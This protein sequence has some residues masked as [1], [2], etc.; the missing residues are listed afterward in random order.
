[1][2]Q[3]ISLACPIAR[4]S[5]LPMFELIVNKLKP[6]E[7]SDELGDLI[8]LREGARDLFREKIKKYEDLLS[9]KHNIIIFYVALDLFD[10]LYQYQ[11]ITKFPPYFL[12]SYHSLK[13]VLCDFFKNYDPDKIFSVDFH[14][15]FESIQSIYLINENKLTELIQN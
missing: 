14:Q 11:H 6:P 15:R 10:N 12:E 2:E 4:D 3:I 7:A 13:N 5:V 1:P 9:H 8:K